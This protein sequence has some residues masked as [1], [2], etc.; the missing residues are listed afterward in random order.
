ML[1]SAHNSASSGNEPATGEANPYT[2]WRL[3]KESVTKRLRAP[4]TAE[5][6]DDGYL[7]MQ[8]HV[9]RDIGKH[10]TQKD[11][12]VK[13]EVDSQNGFGARLRA[14]YSCSI[15]WVG[16]DQYRV[17]STHVDTR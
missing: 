16:N 3:C 1:H 17:N 6:V 9:F 13:G 15:T 11:F 8:S 14:E 2:M 5:F 12:L 4:S 7:A 10:K